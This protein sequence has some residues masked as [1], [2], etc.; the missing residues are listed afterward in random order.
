MKQLTLLFVLAILCIVPLRAQSV[1]DAPPAEEIA[2]AYVETIGGADA[3]M[4]LS[5]LQMNGKVS[6]Q[7]MTFPVTMTTASGDKNRFEM[8]IQ[9]NKMI[10][11]YDGETAWQYFPMQGITE[12]KAMTDEEATDL[13]ESPFLDVFINYADRGYQLENVEGKDVE[14]TATYG[15][16]VTNDQGFDRIYYFDT[17]TMVPLLVTFTARSGQMKG[18]AMESFMSDY[19][20]VEGLVL[21]MFMQQKVNGQEMMSMTFDEITLDP[22]LDPAFFTMESME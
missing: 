1:T 4:Q 21:P 11:A 16:H 8:D 14:G 20:E 17:E 22:E 12:P 7:G 9:G 15:I 5:A 18:V 3:W 6:M 13:K 2:A 10:Q 19:E